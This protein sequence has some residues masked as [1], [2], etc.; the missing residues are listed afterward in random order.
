ME[1][2]FT[3]RY[4]FKILISVSFILG[5]VFFYVNH[6]DF[7][8]S[9]IE[10]GKMN[11]SNLGYA[12]LRI[13]GGLIIPATFIIPSMFEYGRIK[14]ARI[15]FI[16]YG[17]CHLL[18]LSWIIYFFALQPAGDFFNPDKVM[19][20]LRVDG[21]FV[22]QFTFWDTYGL[23]SILFSIIYGVAAI[24]TGIYFDKEKNTVKW[25]VFLLLALRV[26][27]PFINNIAFQGRVYS[28]FWITNNYLELAAQLCFTIAIF[29][30]AS[31]NSSWIEFVW[32]QI[33]FSE[34]ED[35]E[36]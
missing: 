30:A 7:I 34:N 12:L 13:V 15:S 17:I 8:S 18:T 4:A 9:A 3:K 28:L 24:Y 36:D 5:I 10:Y 14:L 35:D 25:L 6:I 19:H 27:L 31:E 29:V 32:D 26:L 33:A 16:A 22:Y 1:T 2:S 11:V 23:I 20:F 21:G